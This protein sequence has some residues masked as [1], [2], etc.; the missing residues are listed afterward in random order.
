MVRRALKFAIGPSVG[1]VAGSLA[2][3][4]MNPHLHN[5]TWPS[6]GAQGALYLPVSYAVCFLVGLLLAWINARRNRGR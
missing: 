4:V 2:Y 3:R 6:I 1:V 5:E